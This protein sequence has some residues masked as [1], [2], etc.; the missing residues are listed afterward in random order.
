[1]QCVPVLY[2]F[3]LYKIIHYFFCRWVQKLFKSISHSVPR[4]TTCTF[5]YVPEIFYMYMKWSIKV[6]YTLYM[7]YKYYTCSKI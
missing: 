3:E 2:Q 7:T 4:E 6:H 1:M 5:S